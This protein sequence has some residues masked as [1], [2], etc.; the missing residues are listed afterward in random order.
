[1]KQ[2]LKDPVGEPRFLKELPPLILAS[3][4]PR[5]RELL[6]RLTEDF[7]VVASSFNEAPLMHASLSPEELVLS[8]SEGKARAIQNVPE[9]AVVIGGDTVVVSP[10][11]T[12]FGIPKD[13]EDAFSMLLALS[14]RT[15]RVVT[16]VTLLQN[17]RCRRFFVTTEVEFYPLSEEEILWY[18]ET[19]EPFD[20]AG[21][22]GIQGKGSLLVREIRG[23]YANVVG[24]PVAELARNLQS[25]L[26]IQKVSLA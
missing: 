11:G 25:F 5:R 15:H 24:L 6:S 20:K 12:V 21:A 1:M 23:D 19:G 22:Y 10:E 18:L 3:R 13:R 4:S 9:N 17:A 14:G 16:G 7:Q 26:N 2:T 8:L